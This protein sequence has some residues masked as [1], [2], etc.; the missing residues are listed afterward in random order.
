M[1]PGV[2]RGGQRV[3]REHI[4]GAPRELVTVENCGSWQILPDTDLRSGGQYNPPP[5]APLSRSHRQ[6]P[7]NKDSPHTLPP[8]PSCPNSFPPWPCRAWRS[9]CV[10]VCV[11]VS[12]W[13]DRSVKSSLARGLCRGRGRGGGLGW[14]TGAAKIYRNRQKAWGVKTGKRFH[15]AMLLCLSFTVLTLHC[16]CW[17]KL[18]FY[19]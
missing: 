13:C 6:K 19:L 17:E 1:A 9:V 16:R 5:P 7:P 18:H 8:T 12:V 14:H 11:S 15:L 10:C 4:V 2:S 3:C